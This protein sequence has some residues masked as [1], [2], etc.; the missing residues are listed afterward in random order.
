MERYGDEEQRR[1][2][3]PI[4]PALRAGTQ[5]EALGRGDGGRAPASRRGSAGT[6]GSAASLLLSDT[7][8]CI[9]SSSLLASGQPAPA[10]RPRGLLR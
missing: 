5:R 7:F 10:T 2:A 6:G 8:H 3:P 4:G 1:D 9:A